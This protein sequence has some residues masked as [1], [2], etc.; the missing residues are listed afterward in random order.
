MLCACMTSN[1]DK[2]GA[3][4]ELCFASVQLLAVLNYDLTD[5]TTV[6]AKCSSLAIQSP[7]VEI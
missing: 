1:M 6:T 3:A 4:K 2:N 7:H 5:W